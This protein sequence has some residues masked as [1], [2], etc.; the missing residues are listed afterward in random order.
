MLWLVVLTFLFLISYVLLDG[1]RS[2]QKNSLKKNNK[3]IILDL[4]TSMTGGFFLVI[5]FMVIGESAGKD[6]SYAN[7]VGDFFNSS[8]WRISRLFLS[9]YKGTLFTFIFGSLFT[10]LII[11]LKRQYNKNL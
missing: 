6:G 8:N 11:W 1:G 9:Y 7:I 4:I 10:Y 3:I 5:F 2:D